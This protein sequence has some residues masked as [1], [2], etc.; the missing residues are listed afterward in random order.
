MPFWYSGTR[1]GDFT[2][3]D[4]GM[5]RWLAGP[6]LGMGNHCR[7]VTNA[8]ASSR[9]CTRDGRWSP[10][11]GLQEQASNCTVLLRPK[12]VVANDRGIGAHAERE[13]SVEEMSESEPL[14]DASI[15][16]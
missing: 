7:C 5:W 3:V 8:S 12:G 16:P 15:V 6:D 4:G 13:V 10:A 1:L 2:T 11:I 14:D 9:C